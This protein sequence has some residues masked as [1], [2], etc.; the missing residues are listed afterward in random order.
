M[1]DLK[2]CPSCGIQVETYTMLQ[3]G[4][5]KPYCSSCGLDLS[6]VEKTVKA[7]ALKCIVLAEDSETL[8]KTL[9][10]SLVESGL[11]SGVVSASNGVEFVS[12]VTKRFRENLPVSL[13]ILDVEMPVLSGIQAAVSLREIEKSFNK[14]RRVPLL[15]FTAKKCDDKFKAILKKLQPSSYVN[16]GASGDPTDLVQR[17]EKVLYMLLHRKG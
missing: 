13:A 11:A 6:N 1:G 3:D 9:G 14:Q 8:R 16:K 10:K 12:A 7:E 5:E 2:Y 15:F 17:V 4:E